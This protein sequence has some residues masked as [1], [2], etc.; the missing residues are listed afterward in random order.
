MPH[1][2]TPSGINWFYEEKGK[3]KMLV[4][5]HG[6]SFDSKV[7]SKQIDNFKGYK[8]ITLDLPGHGNSG[9]KKE[10]DSVKDLHFIFEK[11]K[12]DKINL[13]GHSFGGF[14]AL[15]FTLNY[16]QLTHKIVLIGT[17]AKFVK[18]ADYEFGL[19]EKDVE[20]LRSFIADNYPEILCIFMRWLFTNQERG[21]NG[22]REIWDAISKRKIWPKKEALGEFLN[23]IEKD[24]LRNGLKKINQPVLIISGSDDPICP[25]ESQNY[26][27]KEIRNSRVELFE[28]CGHLP[29]LT[30][31]D[32]F[33]ELI[34]DFIK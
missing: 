32:K 15:K 21:Q 14:I 31:A 34:K 20:K 29:F 9:Y 28:N 6:W 30:S 12:L 24:D 11:L 26:L 5:I 33:N 16:P 18:S 4:F 17:N 2:E 27:G 7:W 1:I 3:G 10:I 25:V 19:S 22:F 8:I 13:I 23:I